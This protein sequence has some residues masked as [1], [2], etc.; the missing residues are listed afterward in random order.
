M[1][2]KDERASVE[3]DCLLQPSGR[4][5]AIL[6]VIGLSGS[7]VADSFMDLPS[8]ICGTPNYT[9]CESSPNSEHIP[10][11]LTSTGDVAPAPPVLSSSL[12]TSIGQKNLRRRRTI[13]SSSVSSGSSSGSLSGIATGN[14]TSCS[15]SNNANSSSGSN[16]NNSGCGIDNVNTSRLSPTSWIKSN[17]T[18]IGNSPLTS[19]LRG[20]PH[21][22]SPPSIPLV[23]SVSSSCL[24][25]SVSLSS[26]TSSFPVESMSSTPVPELVKSASCPSLSSNCVP[27]GSVSGYDISVSKNDHI[28]SLLSPPF[29][30]AVTSSGAG[31]VFPMS[32]TYTDLSPCGDSGSRSIFSELVME[33]DR[34][35]GRSSKLTVGKQDLVNVAVE[36]EDMTM[37]EYSNIGDERCG[38]N[39]KISSKDIKIIDTS[40]RGQCGLFSSV[41]RGAG[42]VTSLSLDSGKSTLCKSSISGS[43]YP[44]LEVICTAEERSDLTQ[45]PVLSTADRSDNDPTDGA[46]LSEQDLDI[47]STMVKAGVD[48]FNNQVDQYNS[49]ASSKVAHPPLPLIE[50]VVDCI[51]LREMSPTVAAKK[52]I[53]RIY[54]KKLDKKKMAKSDIMSKLKKKNSIVNSLC[55]LLLMEV[56]VFRG[57]SSTSLAKCETMNENSTSTTSLST[58]QSNYKMFSKSAACFLY[59]FIFFEN[60]DRMR[61]DY[62]SYNSLMTKLS[63]K[64]IAKCFGKLKIWFD[65]KIDGKFWANEVVVAWLL[66]IHDEPMSTLSSSPSKVSNSNEKLN[67]TCMISDSEELVCSEDDILNRVASHMNDNYKDSMFLKSLASTLSKLTT[68]G[69]DDEQDRVDRLMPHVDD[70]GSSV[71]EGQSGES[72]VLKLFDKKQASIA[73]PTGL[74]LSTTASGISESLANADDMEV[75]SDGPGLVDGVDLT[76]NTFIEG[77]HKSK[78]QIGGGGVTSVKKKNSLVSARVSLNGHRTSMEGRLRSQQQ[79]VTVAK[80]LS[81]SSSTSQVSRAGSK[82]LGKSTLSMDGLKSN[83]HDVKGMSNKRGR[84]DI[85]LFQPPNGRNKHGF[86]RADNNGLQQKKLFDTARADEVPP[87]PAG[88]SHNKRLRPRDFK[89][90]DN[91]DGI[92]VQDTPVVKRSKGGSRS[93][94]AAVVA[95]TPMKPTK[96]N[97]I[98]D[99][100]VRKKSNGRAMVVASTPM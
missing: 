72:L 20:N 89:V 79:Q 14:P 77:L 6:V 71:T 78:Q 54:G 87:R 29:V 86:K 37:L 36:G 62:K 5:S 2:D 75:Q 91:S 99:T 10:T 55:Q 69:D 57:S 66:A 73:V 22:T 27:G 67:G 65:L 84:N 3:Y 46:G 92:I 48:Y 97:M 16:G 51:F 30:A 26:N 24:T 9:S 19:P 98:A 31:Y 47:K 49:T 59:M 58:N 38:G 100:P 13:L 7:H 88:A 90:D 95:D 74:K 35:A 68:V 21:Y 33:G 63:T 96:S 56:S 44:N 80:F 12:S 94:V 25:T 1:R 17:V 28:S 42:V 4:L 23:S 41:M 64:G 81:R 40:G 45:P 18:T 82:N 11:S 8:R 50:F 60:E 43:S 70:V 83:V 61:K 76:Q 52:I 15:T 32:N 34:E 53:K 39:E 85:P 93:S